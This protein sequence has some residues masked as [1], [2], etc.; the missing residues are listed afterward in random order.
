MKEKNQHNP[1][2][3]MME[4]DEDILWLSAQPGVPFMRHAQRLVFG[5]L[6]VSAFYLL[7]V[8][9]PSPYPYPNVLPVAAMCSAMLFPVCFM[10]YMIYARSEAR[11]RAHAYMLTDRHIYT[12]TPQG[13][14]AFYPLERI[15]ELYP[16]NS[17]TISLDVGAPKPV[18]LKYIR[19]ARGIA[20]LMENARLDRLDDLDEYEE[21]ID[22]REEQA[23]SL[24]RYA[25]RR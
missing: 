4:E 9:M 20:T 7:P 13:G 11:Q 25:G 14:A 21:D 6:L 19:N 8:L 3:N 24:R 23:Q 2:I 12:S 1:F 16:S 17:Q 18:A 15:Y 5:W 22:E 10:C